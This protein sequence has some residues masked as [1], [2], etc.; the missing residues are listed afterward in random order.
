MHGSILPVVGVAL[1]SLLEI[2]T[3]CRKYQKPQAEQL[4]NWAISG[5]I[6]GPGGIFGVIYHSETMDNQ[7]RARNYANVPVFSDPMCVWVC[8]RPCML[9]SYALCAISCVCVV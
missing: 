4:P 8:V 5:I 6:E 1:F 9:V 3:G 2:S 7:A